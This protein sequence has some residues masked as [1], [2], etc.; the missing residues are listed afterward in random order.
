MSQTKKLIFQ[1]CAFKRVFNY[2][3]RSFYAETIVRKNAKGKTDINKIIE[4]VKLS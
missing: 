4:H 2:G 1:K 3:I